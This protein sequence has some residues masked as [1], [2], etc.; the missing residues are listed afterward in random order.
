MAATIIDKLYG[1]L[2]WDE[3]LGEGW[4]G[5]VEFEPG[6][7]VKISVWRLDPM[8]FTA[9]RRTHRIFEKIQR[10]KA[11][12]IEFLADDLHKDYNQEWRK[13]GEKRL[14]RA[15]LLDKLKRELEW[16]SVSFQ[17]DETLYI[18]FKTE[19]FDGFTPIV[20][21]DK[22]GDCVDAELV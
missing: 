18:I 14:D 7:S 21:L 11:K 15:E 13:S 5:S 6:A 9:V 8:D 4:T 16:E 19:M 20:N 1:K 22:N 10:E 12:I 2:A 17:Q 3:E